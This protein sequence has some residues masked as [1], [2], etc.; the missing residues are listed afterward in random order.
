MLMIISKF[1]K[2]SIIQRYLSEVYGT[3]VCFWII[4]TIIN[5]TSILSLFNNDIIVKNYILIWRNIFKGVTMDE[6]TYFKS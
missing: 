2:H 3:Y 4:K 1:L 6:K 5:K